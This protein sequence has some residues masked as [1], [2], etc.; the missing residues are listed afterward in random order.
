MCM[1]ARLGYDLPNDLPKSIGGKEGS[2]HPKTKIT[3]TIEG[4]SYL[5]LLNLAPVIR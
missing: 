1:E 3:A 2:C 5:L 4:G